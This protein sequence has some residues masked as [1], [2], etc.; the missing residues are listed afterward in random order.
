MTWIVRLVRLLLLIVV[1]RVVWRL[2]HRTSG[3]TPREGTARPGDRAASGTEE[4]MARD[5]VCGTFV[6][7]SRA[8]SAAEGSQTHYFCSERCRQT[9]RARMPAGAASR[10]A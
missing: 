10:G 2:F 7:R 8:L 5:P 9:F 4:P 6:V 3:G 1:A